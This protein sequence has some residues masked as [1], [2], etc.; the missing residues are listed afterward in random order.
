MC[1]KK[2][3]KKEKS[4][5]EVIP[6]FQQKCSLVNFQQIVKMVKPKAKIEVWDVLR[7]N[8]FWPMISS[9]YHSKVQ[10]N[11]FTKH[12]RDLEIIL[13]YYDVEKRKFFFG[14][15]EMEIMME[16]IERIFGLPNSGEVIKKN[17]GRNM[18]KD[19]RKLSAIFDVKIIKD[20]AD[21][22]VL[23]KRLEAEVDKEEK[24]D[25]RII[26]ALIIMVLFTTCFFSKS[27]VSI[28]WDLINACEDIERINRY[29]WPKMNLEFL[30][31]GFMR[32]EKE[33]PEVLSGCLI[34]IY[35]WFVENTQGIMVRKNDTTTGRNNRRYA[36]HL[37]EYRLALKDKRIAELS[38]QVFQINMQL[39][40]INTA[41]GHLTKSIM[42]LGALWDAPP[43][44]FNR[45]GCVR[46]NV[47][48]TNPESSDQ[49]RS[50]PY[51]LW[52]PTSK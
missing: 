48:C 21:K 31:N 12:E 37:Y 20:T 15:K 18:D 51:S 17:V 26:A 30:L 29:N 46:I 47:A 22:Q 7:K 33:K 24:G 42:E 5:S 9:I 40:E 25:V 10:E 32:H 19:K 8:S 52:P 11:H 1:K 27:T 34:L 49:Q 39:I 3:E 41:I 23:L 43:P 38:Q 16:D 44:V 14:D 50:K 13:Q 36:Y 2:S 35:Y 6:T 4:R 28:T 45:R